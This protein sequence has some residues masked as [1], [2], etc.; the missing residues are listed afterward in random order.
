M[1]NEPFTTKGLY[2]FFLLCA[3][4]FLVTAALSRSQQPAVEAGVD[5]GFTD[6]F[7]SYALNQFPAA[8]WTRAGHNNSFVYTEP[9]GW[10]GSHGKGLKL[11]GIFSDDPNFADCGGSVAYRYLNGAAPY[12]ITFWVANGDQ[13]HA[14]CQTPNHNAYAAVELST[15]P[16][17][18]TSGGDPINHRG[19]IEFN[20]NGQ[21]MGGQ[22]EQDESG[23]SFL[24]TFNPDQWYKVRI[25][26]E[27]VDANT[28]SLHFWIDDID[29]GL[30]NYPAKSYEDALAYL[31]LW[32]AE[33]VA[34]FDDITVE[35]QPIIFDE[36][37][38]L[39]NVRR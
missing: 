39:P 16:N 4:A 5:W 30:Y 25:R 14:G 9:H 12:D 36:F 28:V 18:E 11:I 8:N 21:V 34:W 2:R 20:G 37:V 33:G 23:G 7:E 15:N 32:G 38:Y 31:G 3:F 24:G 10:W 19:L 13:S 29:R 27:R 35:A 17:W 26:Y 1:M 22:F 6:N